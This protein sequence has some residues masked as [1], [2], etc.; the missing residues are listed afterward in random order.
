MVNRGLMQ[1]RESVFNAHRSFVL[2]ELKDGEKSEVCSIAIVSRDLRTKTT[3]QAPHTKKGAH[4]MHGLIP[5]NG[6]ARCRAR[7]T[8]A[9][10]G[11]TPWNQRR[12]AI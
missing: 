10:G 11:T 4:L 8:A 7:A 1:Q 2:G 5:V 12:P 9:P 3:A 6:P